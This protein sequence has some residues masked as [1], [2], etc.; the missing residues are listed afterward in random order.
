MHRTKYIESTCTIL[1]ESVNKCYLASSTGISEVWT[2]VFGGVKR[3]KT[4]VHLCRSSIT[5]NLRRRFQMEMK[6]LNPFRSLNGSSPCNHYVPPPQCF[7]PFI[8]ANSNIPYPIRLHA[9]S[10]LRKRPQEKPL[11]VT[12]FGSCI[13]KLGHR[14][15]ERVPIF[16]TNFAKEL[17]LRISTV[18][19][20]LWCFFWVESI[21]CSLSKFSVV[22]YVTPK[23]N[24]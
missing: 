20:K 1:L 19:S 22:Y 18:P 24:V 13:K 23:I 11:R 4:M 10:V 7:F 2:R 8:S 15:L 12:G 3:V 17:P 9:P 14:I 6:I 21:V 5:K 16:Q